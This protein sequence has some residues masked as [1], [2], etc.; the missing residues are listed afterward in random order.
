MDGEVGGLAR[1]QADKGAGDQRCPGRVAP[2]TTVVRHFS[3]LDSDSADWKVAY[4]WQQTGLDKLRCL[5]TS[6]HMGMSMGPLPGD[7]T[8][9]GGST[10]STLARRMNRA[11]HD[12]VWPLSNAWDSLLP[13]MSTQMRI[14]GVQVRGEADACPS[15][16][17]CAETEHQGLWHMA[18]GCGLKL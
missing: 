1:D 10:N 3:R 7:Y 4:P 8:V 13:R 16:S 2:M 17:R 18:G 11:K 5:G 12:A 6:G 15:P 9:Y 14:D